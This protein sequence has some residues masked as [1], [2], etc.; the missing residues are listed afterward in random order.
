MQQ[1]NINQSIQNGL[2]ALQ[3][4]APGEARA[5]FQGLIKQGIQNASIWLALGLACRDLGDFAAGQ[6]AADKSIELER[7]NPRAYILKADLYYDQNDHQSAVAFYRIALNSSPQNTQTPE[8]LKVQ[9]SRAQKRCDDILANYTDYLNGILHDD[10][11]AAGISA[12]RAK[13]SL[14]I[15]TGQ[16][17][18][19]TQQPQTYFFPELPDIGFYDP[20]DFAWVSE[21]EAKTDIIRT[22]LEGAI[23]QVPQD[24]SAYLQ[25]S[26]D[27][28]QN[29]FHGMKGSDSWSAY[30]LWK[31]GEL[32]DGAAVQC[33][34]T[35]AAMKKI[36]FPEMQGRAPNILFSLLKAGAKIPPHNGLINTRLI[37]HLPLI[38][39][40]GCGF[41]VG[42]DIR[43][44][45][46]GKVWLFDDTIEHEAWN[47]SDQDRYILLFEVWKPELSSIEQE[48]VAKI[49]E[50]VDGYSSASQPV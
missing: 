16:K 19:Y 7:R 49:L 45:Q 10:M 44:W 32:V 12:R 22:E 6:S 41:R 30:Y 24:F 28:P 46:E 37:C 35:V 15:M 27:R 18:P 38:V 50:S 4:N 13:L 20:V 29:D 11:K 21:L 14:D 39:P 23:Q 48:L 36:K 40:E 9:L 31:D 43:E 34:E 26:D 8:D 42:N 17:T 2:Q 5:I 1:N 25:G 33:P 3:R 47:N